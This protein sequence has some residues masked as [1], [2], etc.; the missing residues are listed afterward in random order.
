MHGGWEDT[1]SDCQWNDR[2]EKEKLQ[3][4][5]TLEDFERLM[6][7]STEPSKSNQNEAIT[8]PLLPSQI[9]HACWRAPQTP[10]SKVEQE[11]ARAEMVLL[12]YVTISIFLFSFM[13]VLLT[14]NSFAF[15]IKQRK[16]IECQV[17]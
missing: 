7:L 13:T 10:V 14:N 15:F 8:G 2:D 12:L 9:G 1:M 17:Q 16:P 11:K 3:M 6:T 4:E 5:K